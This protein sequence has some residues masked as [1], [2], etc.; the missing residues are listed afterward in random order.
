M[1]NRT[2][3][4]QKNAPLTHCMAVHKKRIMNCYFIFI[5]K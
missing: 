4:T 5:L 3:D 1:R 2:A